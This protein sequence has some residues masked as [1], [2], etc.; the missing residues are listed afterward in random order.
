VWTH[1]WAPGLVFAV[2][3]TRLAPTGSAGVPGMDV[4]AARLALGDDTR[5]D[6]DLGAEHR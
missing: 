6:R 3:S 4:A 5:A 2:T 1:G